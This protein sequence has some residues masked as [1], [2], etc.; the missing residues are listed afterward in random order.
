[1]DPRP[2][3]TICAKLLDHLASRGLA[4]RSG[5]RASVVCMLL[6]GAGCGA[7]SLAADAGVRAPVTDASPETRTGAPLTI[8]GAEAA[9]RLS[10]FLWK[11]EPDPV[12]L[13]SVDATP[14]A[15]SEDVRRL[16]LQML[17]DARSRVGVGAFFRWWLRLDL[18]ADVE[19][20][21]TLFP[22]FSPA[23]KVAMAAEPEAFGVFV[24]LDGDHRYPTLMMA[25]FSFL[26]ESLASVYGV[27]GV[28]GDELRRV[29]LDPAQRAGL[30]TQPGLLAMT[31]STQNASASARGYFILRRLL[32]AVAP[33]AP[34]GE[35]GGEPP[36]DMTN[37]QWIEAQTANADCRVCHEALDPIGY[38]LGNFDA[39]GQ[40]G[41]TEHGLPVDVRGALTL[42]LSTTRDRVTFEGPL[43]LA[44]LLATRPEAQTCFARQWLRF[45]VGRELTMADEPTLTIA[46]ARF[47]AADLSIR[48]L[49]GAVASSEAFLAP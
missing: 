16:A 28:V 42:W 15:T 10:R 13:A 17:G 49:I 21:P 29:S 24:T 12:L 20:D 6:L 22:R 5:L 11:Q 3:V 18:V 35:A 48:E 47:H 23:M 43:Q 41:T 2:A 39:I 37:R 25:P 26:N 30:I 34:P 40:F 32:C 1:M 31:H 27:A 8:N 36:P 14:L 7:R 19:K 46:D 44:A 38:G 33:E 4:P 45:A 9:G